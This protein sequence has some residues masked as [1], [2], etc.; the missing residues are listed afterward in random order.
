MN[1]VARTD[2]YFISTIIKLFVCYD[3]PPW[4]AILRVRF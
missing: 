2:S 4:L 3:A 1:D